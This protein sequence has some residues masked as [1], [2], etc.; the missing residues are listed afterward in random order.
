MVLQSVM[1]QTGLQLV[2][3]FEMSQIYFGKKKNEKSIGQKPKNKTQGKFSLF[4]IFVGFVSRR[5]SALLFLKQPDPF[6]FF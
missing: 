3:T 4:D 1:P 5:S 2:S 6:F